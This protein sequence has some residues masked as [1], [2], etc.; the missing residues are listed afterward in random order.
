IVELGR[1]CIVGA[2][3]Q[4]YE[5][6]PLFRSFVQVTECELERVVER[7][8]AISA[9]LIQ[10]FAELG[11][12]AGEWYRSRKRKPGPRIEIHNEHFVLQMAGVDELPCGIHDVILFPSHTAAVI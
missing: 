10:S 9:S 11:S 12:I 1:A 5:C 7:G 8:G 4:Q 3:A 6:L 2:V